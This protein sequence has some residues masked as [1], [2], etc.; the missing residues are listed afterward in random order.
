MVTTGDTVYARSVHEIYVVC[1]LND[2]LQ[3]ERDR[4][5]QFNVSD[6]AVTCSQHL[7]PAAA[8]GRRFVVLPQ[9]DVYCVTVA[10]RHVASRIQTP[11][12]ID[13]QQS[14]ELTVRCT[15]DK[16]PINVP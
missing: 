5:D 16:L 2:V 11:P 7:M 8:P 14:N 1:L 4:C 3:C 13:I 6:D 12:L 10:S 15:T 9:I